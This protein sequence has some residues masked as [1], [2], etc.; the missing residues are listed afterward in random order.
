[1]AS[2]TNTALHHGSGGGKQTGA[3]HFSIG[4]P[5]FLRPTN[6]TLYSI[7]VGGGS[8][9][10]RG[11]EEGGFSF[12]VPLSLFPPSRIFMIAGPS[13][14]PSSPPPSSLLPEKREDRGKR[15]GKG[16]LFSFK[17]S[18]SSVVFRPPLSFLGLLVLALFGEQEEDEEER[19]MPHHHP[20]SSIWKAEVAAIKYFYQPPLVNTELK[21][22]TK[23]SMKQKS[24]N[25]F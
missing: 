20:R 12:P 18:F 10:R 2:L 22:L 3:S 19:G 24:F 8:K 23:K 7:W 4:I 15:K 17:V 13:S 21:N 16:G 1:M 5:P 6:T 11:E 25:R 14:T 9:R